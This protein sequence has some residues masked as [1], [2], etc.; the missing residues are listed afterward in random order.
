MLGL[1]EYSIKLC[2]G[3]MEPKD[4]E[5]VCPLCGYSPDVPSLPEYLSPRDLPE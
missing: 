3:C 5:G 4:T 1:A 2:M